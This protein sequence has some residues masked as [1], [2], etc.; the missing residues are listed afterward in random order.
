VDPDHDHPGSYDVGVTSPVTPLPASALLAPVSCWADEEI[1]TRTRRTRRRLLLAAAALFDEAGYRG[2]SLS[3]I[4]AAAGL[5]K[6]ALYFHFRSKYVLA[7]ALCTEMERS[8]HAV[9]GEIAGR[10]LDPLWRLLVE[11]DSYIARWMYDPIVRGSTR[12]LDDPELVPLRARA[13]S[14]WETA[15]IE[16]LT[17]ASESGLLAAEVDPRRAG[18]AVVAIATG[19]YALADGPDDLWARTSESW[20]GLLPI[21]A[22]RPWREGF[23]SSPWRGRPGPDPEA[24]RLAR[25]P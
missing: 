23:A 12:S 25:E 18:R 19:N 10:D 3:D 22:S 16:R 8:W 9:E 17:E 15:T 4:L 13:F 6:G 14:R 1:G 2:A 5:T 24:Y 11:T 20:E 21:M 7:E